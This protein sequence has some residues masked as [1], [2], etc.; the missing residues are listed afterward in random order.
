MIPQDVVP[1]LG[2]LTI[3]GGAFALTFVDPWL[4]RR[5]YRHWRR[6]LTNDTDR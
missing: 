6:S 2:L 3:V 1:I 5:R 4:E